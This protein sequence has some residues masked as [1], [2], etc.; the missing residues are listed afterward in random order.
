[1]KN[2]SETVEKEITVP[3]QT[4]YVREVSSVIL[5]QLQA[6]GVGESALFDIR[7]CVEETVRNAMQHGNALDKDAG[8]K[9]K[10]A[11]SDSLFTVEVE[12][13]G[14]G[15]DHGN[16]PD[17]T[18]DE[19]IMKVSGRGVYLVRRLMDKVEYNKKGNKVKLT[20]KL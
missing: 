16:V 17:P 12:D 13:S 20:K 9:I 15:F 19:N 14:A 2:R 6:R 5:K 7:L 4:R 8:V 3:S 18:T 10:Y 1:M 11:I